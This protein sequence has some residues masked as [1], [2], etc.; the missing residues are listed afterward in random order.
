MYQFLL[1]DSKL[2]TGIHKHNSHDT[3]IKKDNLLTVLISITSGPNNGYLRDTA[4]E[5]W[6]TPCINSPICD[7]HY[8]IDTLNIT[9]DLILENKLYND[10]SFRNECELMS[11]HPKYIHYGNAPIDSSPELMFVSEDKPDYY[12]RRMYKIDWKYCFMKWANTTFS[13]NKVQ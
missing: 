3:K 8:F 9:K 11:R 4:R 13:F 7:Y 6:L 12:Y 10:I 2:N 5:T 1:C